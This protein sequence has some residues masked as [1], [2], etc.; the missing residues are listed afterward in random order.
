MSLA[1]GESF[2]RDRPIGLLPLEPEALRRL[3]LL[4]IRTMGGLAALPRHAVQAQFGTAG[5]FAWELANG[6]DDR[7]VMPAPYIE[8]VAE[9]MDFGTPLVS[10]EAILAA[11]E[12]MLAS[13]LR[14]PLRGQRFVRAI[15]VTLTTERGQ[16]WRRKQ[17]LKEPSSDRDRLWRV[18][19]TLV[20]YAGMPGAAAQLRLE[21]AGLTHESGRQPSLFREAARRREELEETLRQL[22]ARYGHCPVGHVVEVEPWSRVPERRMALAEFDP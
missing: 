13:A 15:E 20:E 14:Q 22:K 7:P 1:T 18:L 11:L 5:V 6:H 4:G 19:R 10:R 2:L 16:R 3:R 12:P 9:V 21:L 8:R 17:L